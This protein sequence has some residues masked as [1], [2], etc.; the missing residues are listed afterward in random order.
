MSDYEEKGYMIGVW[1]GIATFVLAWIYCIA[2]GG[3]LFGLGLGLGW[4]PAAILG[5]IVGVIVRFMWGPKP[6][7]LRPDCC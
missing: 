4:L 7:Y 5:A 6:F 2:T 1:T 3:F